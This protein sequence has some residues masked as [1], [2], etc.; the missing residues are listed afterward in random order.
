MKSWNINI[1]LTS[2]ITIMVIVTLLFSTIVLANVWSKE[3]II[4]PDNL[5]LC[6]RVS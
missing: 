3:T 4:E 2:P 6:A 5:E 1:C